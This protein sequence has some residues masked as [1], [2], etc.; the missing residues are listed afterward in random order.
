MSCSFLG[1]RP[2]YVLSI[3][4]LDRITNL[5]DGSTEGDVMTVAL[6]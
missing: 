1:D 5:N 3:Q 4:Y 6:R 2:P